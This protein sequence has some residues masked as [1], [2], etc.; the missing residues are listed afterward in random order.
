MQRAFWKTFSSKTHSYKDDR[1]LLEPA[2]RFV[3]D[4][5]AD[6]A[7]HVMRAVLLQYSAF[8]DAITPEPTNAESETVR[9]RD[10][11]QMCWVI[12]HDKGFYETVKCPEQT[13]RTVISRFYTGFGGDPVWLMSL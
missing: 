8:A 11:L 10:L 6:Q 7:V 5:H 4:K 12:S 13:R 2:V 1:V 9:R 3:F